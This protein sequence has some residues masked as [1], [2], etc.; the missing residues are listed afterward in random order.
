MNLKILSTV[1]AIV[2]ILSLIIFSI[3]VLSIS[4]DTNVYNVTLNPQQS[5][6]ISRY[7][8]INDYLTYRI[9]FVNVSSAIASYIVSPNG[10][11]TAQHQNP[12]NTTGS[13]VTDESGTW[14]LLIMNAGNRTVYLTVEFTVVPETVIFALISAFTLLPLGI[15]MMIINPMKNRID[16]WK[17][18][19]RDY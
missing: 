3:S 13:L 12:L 9:T 1:G 17:R 11:H 10:I 5:E 7:A 6:N 18:K 16:K 14:S 2:I 4:R 8:G 19:R 15:I